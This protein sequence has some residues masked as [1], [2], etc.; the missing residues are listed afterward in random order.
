MEVEITVRVVVDG[1]WCEQ[2]QIYDLP[3]HRCKELFDAGKAAPARSKQAETATV[4]AAEEVV[5]APRKR[6]RG[7]K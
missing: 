4:E 5:S 2:G 6:G 1:I 3:P 7:T